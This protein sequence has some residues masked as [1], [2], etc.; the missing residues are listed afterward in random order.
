[1]LCALQIFYRLCQD[2][3]SL[4]RKTTGLNAHIFPRQEQVLPVVIR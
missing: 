3:R 2:R 1:M 4:G